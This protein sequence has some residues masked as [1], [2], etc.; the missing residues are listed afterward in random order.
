M[1]NAGNNTARHTAGKE[2][3]GEDDRLGR[4]FEVVHDRAAPFA[5]TCMTSIAA[6]FANI[7]VFALTAIKD[8]GVNA[9]VGD[10]IVFTAGRNAGKARSVV[11]FAL[12]A[13]TS[14]L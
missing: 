10:A 12:A 11:D 4:G 7:L 9:A 13:R 14:D 5:E 1:R 2:G 8:E 6:Q 3:K